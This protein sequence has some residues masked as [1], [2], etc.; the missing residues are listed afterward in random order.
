MNDVI[1]VVEYGKRLRVIKIKLK[2]TK[3]KNIYSNTFVLSDYHFTGYGVVINCTHFCV[4]SS[5][6]VDPTNFPS[7]FLSSYQSF[8]RMSNFSSFQRDRIWCYSAN[9]ASFLSKCMVNPSRSTF[10][11]V[12][13]ASYIVVIYIWYN[14]WM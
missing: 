13:M 11:F 3:L 2:G 10:T 9:F 7:Q 6:S 5:I 1:K 14:F 8:F 12:V 4:L